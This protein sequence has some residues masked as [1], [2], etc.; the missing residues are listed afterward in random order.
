MR[1]AIWYYLYNLKNV[2]N[3]HGGVLLLVKLQASANGYNSR[4]VPHMLKNVMLLKKSAFNA[5]LTNLYYHLSLPSCK[6]NDK[7]VGTQNC[8]VLR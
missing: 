1:C 3:T 6:L 4:N 5:C 2:E 8:K 7:T